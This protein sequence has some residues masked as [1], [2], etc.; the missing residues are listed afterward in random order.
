MQEPNRDT[1]SATLIQDLLKEKRR[2]RFWKTLRSLLW[3]A[4][5]GYLIYGI[6]N[7]NSEADSSTSP[8]T[9]RK[10]VSLVRIDGMIAPGGDFSAEALLPNLKRAFADSKASGVLIEI[11][12]PGGTPVQSAIIHDAILSYKAKYKKK[13]I[14]VGEDMMTSGAYFIAVAGDKIYANPNTLTGSIG[15]IMKGFGFVDAIKKLGIER[16]VY[17]AGENKDRLDPFLPQNPDD[18]KKVMEV[19]A[20][21]HKNFVQAVEAGRQGK[22][23]GDEKTLFSGDFWSGDQALQLGLIDGLGNMTDVAHNE[24]GTGTFKQYG[25]SDG[26]M[27]LL[28]GQISNSF[29]KLFY[30]AFSA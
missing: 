8:L 9:G 20:Q 16:R 21:V 14:V 25:S 17:T 27:K 5:F 22:L 28:G 10:Y 18:L 4:I 3:A 6:F 19:E 1:V 29:D 11:N 7:F 2:D 23:K 12:S 24:F 15:V 26:F 13:V 30:T